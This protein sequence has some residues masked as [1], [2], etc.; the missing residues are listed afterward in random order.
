[1]KLAAYLLSGLLLGGVCAAAQDS[2][3]PTAPKDQPQVKVSRD[4]RVPLTDEELASTTAQ[5]DTCY[6]IRAYFFR[7]SE[8]GGVEPAGMATCVRSSQRALKRAQKKPVP[9]APEVRLVH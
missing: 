3:K 2:T 4:A 1:M 9:P 8:A 5:D 6:T 7:P